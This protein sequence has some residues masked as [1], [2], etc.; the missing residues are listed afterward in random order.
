MPFHLIGCTNLFLS[1]VYLA[2][3]FDEQ[4]KKFKH[5]DIYLFLISTTSINLQI[6]LDFFSY[7][8]HALVY[9]LELNK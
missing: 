9:I 6:Y 1:F 3:N 7:N 2:E 4:L 8:L 5:V